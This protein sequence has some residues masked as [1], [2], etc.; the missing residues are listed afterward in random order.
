MKLKAEIYMYRV[1]IADDEELMREGLSATVP[2]NT[3]GFEVVGV[4]KSGEEAVELYDKLKPN[5]VITDIV[6]QDMNGLELIAE[7]KKRNLE[8]EFIIISAYSDFDYVKKALENQVYTYL[9]KPFNDTEMEKALCGVKDKLMA[10]EIRNNAQKYGYD[11]VEVLFKMLY[12]AEHSKM[13][14]KNISII[15]KDYNIKLPDNE[16]IIATIQIDNSTELKEWDSVH[17]MLLDAIDYYISTSKNYILRSRIDKANIVMLIYLGDD[18]KG[19]SYVYSA[20]DAIRNTF[21]TETGRTVTIGISGVAKSLNMIGRIYHQS[22]K[23]VERKVLNE[24]NK[25]IEYIEYKSEIITPVL[26]E[27]EVKDILDGI[28]STIDTDKALE[29]L[30]NYFNMIEKMD[31]IDI[32][33]V[34]NSMA[35]LSILAIKTGIK[36][37]QIM[38]NLFGHTVSPVSEI[39]SL[40]FLSDIK[41]YVLSILYKI[42]ENREIANMYASYSPKVRNAILYI[43]EN[44]AKDITA[45]TAGKEL[46]ISGY[47]LMHIFK[48]E[49]GKTFNEYLSEY[50]IHI[51]C[52]LIRSGKYKIYETGELVGYKNPR[53]FSKKFKSITGKKPSEIRKIDETN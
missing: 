21:H 46:Y 38:K 45:E 20:L 31:N 17:I 52:E 47:H 13:P 26:S 37:I 23:A 50:R 25:I 36:N 30:H 8:T 4:A 9:L 34:K 35:E 40:E 12:E 18:D 3:Y 33:I 16:Y 39:Q 7:I 28:K 10:A 49:T 5:L 42:Y 2:W 27:S 6:M 48:K 15:C 32:D 53:H 1:L 14:A 19:Y 29:P 43:M 44:Y 22:V 41:R 51:A 11:K 24:N